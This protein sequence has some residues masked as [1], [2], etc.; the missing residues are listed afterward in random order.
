MN[1][2]ILKK[3]KRMKKELEPEGFII[4]GYFGS[5]ARGE[6]TS[7]SDIDLL[8]EVKDS[9]ISRHKGLQYFNRYSEIKEKIEHELSLSVDLADQDALGKTGKKYILPEV[10]HV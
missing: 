9:F 7:G 8:F 6:E 3:I 5:Y 2:E 4:I 1:N 10:V